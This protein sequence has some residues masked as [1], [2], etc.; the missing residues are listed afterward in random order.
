MT[1]RN[2]KD[3]LYKQ[4]RENVY[5]RDK[6]ICQWPGCTKKTGLNAH[7]IKTWAEYPGLRFLVDN[8][9]TLCKLHHKQ[10][11]GMED[12]YE[13]VFYKIVA[14]NNGRLQ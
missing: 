14:N 2:Y 7:H 5:A 10:I 8:G 4:W 6:H 13:S 12:I 1:F 3:P 11:K 9:I